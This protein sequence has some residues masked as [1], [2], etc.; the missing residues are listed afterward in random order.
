[1]SINVARW[2]F[3]VVVLCAFFV[4]SSHSSST[5]AFAFGFFI[6]WSERPFAHAHGFPRLAF[7]RDLQNLL[8]HT[9]LTVS[10]GW[11]N[12]T[13]SGVCTPFFPV[14]LLRASRTPRAFGVTR[15]IVPQIRCAEATC[16]CFHLRRTRKPFRRQEFLHLIAIHYKMFSFLRSVLGISDAGLG[17]RRFAWHRRCHWY[18]QLSPCF[19]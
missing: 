10:R 3:L 2:T 8:N 5:A 13:T 19:F 1:M 14:P 17:G 12:R 16:S 6:A 4:T 11:L 7:L 18:L 15:R 9:E